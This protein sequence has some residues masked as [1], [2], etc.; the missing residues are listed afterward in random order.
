MDNNLFPEQEDLLS[1]EEQTELQPEAME[2][3]PEPATASAPEFDAQEPSVQPASEMEMI[4]E[5]DLL[6][7][8]EVREEITADEH[9]MAWHG[10]TH[11]TEPAPEF[12]MSILDHPE[13]SE[14]E[15]EIPDYLREAEALLAQ[16]SEPDSTQP[17]TVAASQ[18]PF[19]SNRSY[20]SSRLAEQ[21]MI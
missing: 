17:E 20:I 4:T 1:P 14:S 19:N 11:P 5:A 8:P 6:T 7:A 15:E 12:D 21:A 10:M 16:E 2:T 3:I 13:L 18:V 9:A